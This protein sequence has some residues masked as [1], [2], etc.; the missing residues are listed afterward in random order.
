MATL[1][2]APFN[3]ADVPGVAPEALSLAFRHLIAEGRGLALL[4]GLSEAHIRDVENV[5]WQVF[6]EECDTRL[7]VALRFRALLSAFTTRRLKNLLLHTGFKSIEAAVTE[8]A[9]QRLNA[10]YGFRQQGFVT[11]LS[12]LAKVRI[13]HSRDLADLARAA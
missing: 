2:A 3:T 12:S 8:A 6:P 13:P 4:T 11:A 7:A 9:T 5:I 10:R 1:A